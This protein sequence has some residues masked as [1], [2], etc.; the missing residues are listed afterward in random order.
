MWLSHQLLLL[1]VISVL[2]RYKTDFSTSIGWYINIISVNEITVFNCKSKITVKM[3]LPYFFMVKFWQPQMPFFS[4]KFY[5]FFLQCS[6][7]VWGLLFGKG[8]T[9]DTCHLS[10]HSSEES[11]IRDEAWTFLLREMGV[12]G[13]GSLLSLKSMNHKWK[14]QR[15]SVIPSKRNIP[16]MKSFLSSHKTCHHLSHWYTVRQVSF[17]VL[18]ADYKNATWYLQF[19]S[20]LYLLLLLMLLE[21]LNFKR[22]R[23]TH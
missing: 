23:G 9:A 4:L 8:F 14:V 10:T 2:Q 7:A 11:G 21:L 22:S 16:N 6:T 3:L 1:V 18:I 19:F 12:C 20:S 15:W 17:L 13:W 5:R